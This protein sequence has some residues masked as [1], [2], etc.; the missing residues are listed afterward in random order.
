[1]TKTPVEVLKEW[2]IKQGEWS[3]SRRAEEIV[4]LIKKNENSVDRI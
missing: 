1:M 2:A 3:I 4:R